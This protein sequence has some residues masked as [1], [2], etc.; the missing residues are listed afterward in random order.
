MISL[1][2][3]GFGKVG[4]ATAAMFDTD[5]TEL[6]IFDPKIANGV[7]IKDIA[8]TSA[9]IFIA[10]PTPFADDG[11]SNV[12]TSI[13][14]NTLEEL[15]HLEYDGPVVVRTTCYP[16]MLDGY[17]LNIVHWPCFIREFQTY[18]EF[19]TDQMV[20]LLGGD[21]DSTQ[22]VEKFIDQ[23]SVISIEFYCAPLNDVAAAKICRNL[24]GAYK[25][26]FWNFVHNTFG[27]SRAIYNLISKLPKQG[28]CQIVG[29][30]NEPGFGGYCFPNNVE[31]AIQHGPANGPDPLLTF[32]RDYNDY[33]HDEYN[34]E[35]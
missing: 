13:L 14:S 20:S 17:D 8:E 28:D 24:Y 29:L 3:I 15:E 6:M 1:G 32:I 21:A 10:V 7:T 33:L 11:S 27:N 30:D 2:M 9:M 35:E 25:V 5:K 12:D 23:I 34:E 22:A 16:G 19:I 18:D 31:L 26:L 4:Q